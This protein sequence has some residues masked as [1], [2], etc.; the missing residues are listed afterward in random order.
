[1]SN[2]SS[3]NTPSSQTSSQN[4]SDLFVNQLRGRWG[5]CRWSWRHCDA[6]SSL[7][8]RYFR[9]RGILVILEIKKKNIKCLSLPIHAHSHSL[10]SLPSSPSLIIRCDYN[11]QL[12]AQPINT[13]SNYDNYWRVIVKTTFIE[14]INTHSQKKRHYELYSIYT[15]THKWHTQYILNS[16]SSC[17]INDMQSFVQNSKKG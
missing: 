13:H 17:I 16:L 2:D 7:L 12:S 9:W 6:P 4:Q 8:S 11:H 5:G 14:S 3:Q 1:M 10:M 15:H